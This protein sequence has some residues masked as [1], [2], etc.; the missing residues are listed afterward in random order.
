MNLSKGLSRLTRKGTNYLLW[1]NNAK[2][3]QK[4]Q[5]GKYYNG[6]QGMKTQVNN[7]SSLLP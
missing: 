4:Q 3:K 2:T 5:P 1:Q 7:M 6:T